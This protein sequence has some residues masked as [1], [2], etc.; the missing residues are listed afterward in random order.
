LPRWDDGL[1]E[2][3]HP[4]TENAAVDDCERPIV[5]HCRATEKVACVC[6]SRAHQAALIRCVLRCVFQLQS[7]LKKRRPTDGR[8]VKL[9][10][11]LI[12]EDDAE[13]DG[14]TKQ[15]EEGLL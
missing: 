4:T 7:A 6:R 11:A 10:V 1:E 8:V 14:K 5:A 2:G 12:V 15:G 3:E 9:T 13:R